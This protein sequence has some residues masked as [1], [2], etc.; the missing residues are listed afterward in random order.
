MSLID[1]YYLS[2]DNLVKISCLLLGNYSIIVCLWFIILINGL[3]FPLR[4]HMMI[5]LFHSTEEW[6]YYHH[7]ELKFK[8]RKKPFLLNYLDRSHR[9]KFDEE[10]FTSHPA[11][12]D[13]GEDSKK[14]KNRN[15]LCVVCPLV[16]F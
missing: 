11:Y 4:R 15:W 5:I 7:L 10:C 12:I 8:W 1:Y 2:I 9:K 3:F 6:D 14:A 13:V 16:W